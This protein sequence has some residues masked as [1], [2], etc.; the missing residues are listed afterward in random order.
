MTKR[1]PKTI[2]RFLPLH[3]SVLQATPVVT[4]LSVS[5]ASFQI[6]CRPMSR[7]LH[8]GSLAILVVGFRWG[9]LQGNLNLCSEKSVCTSRVIYTVLLGKS[10]A[11]VTIRDPVSSVTSTFKFECFSKLSLS[12]SRA[13][14]LLSCMRLLI[15]AALQIVCETRS[16][17]WCMHNVILILGVIHT[18]TRVRWMLSM[19]ANSR[20][21]FRQ[22]RRV[23]GI[24]LSKP[25]ARDETPERPHS[26]LEV[27]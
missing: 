4:M 8:A 15:L 6:L 21:V 11:I 20:R 23:L 22:K 9:P 17:L 18:V 13:L 12:G 10:N 5:N 1:F 24:S 26:E 14:F 2:P 25:D 3:S 19:G 7:S 27:V 16:A